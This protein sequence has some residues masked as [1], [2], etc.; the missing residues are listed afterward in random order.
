MAITRPAA[1]AP[2]GRR[3][4]RDRRLAVAPVDPGLEARR[5]SSPVASSRRSGRG[6][7]GA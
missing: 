7:A 4:V 5:M 3:H 2:L 6:A 1:V